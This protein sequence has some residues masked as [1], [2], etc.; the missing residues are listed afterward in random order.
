M[1]TELFTLFMGRL[2][3]LIVLC[4]PLEVFWMALDV[5]ILHICL[6]FFCLTLGGGT[7]TIR[8]ICDFFFH[9]ACIKFCEWAGNWKILSFYPNIFYLREPFASKESISIII[10]FFYVDLKFLYVKVAPLKIILMC[11]FKGNFVFIILKV[12]LFLL[13]IIQTI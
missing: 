12:T 10:W 5:L 9:F 11:I 4:F 13:K 3:I 7:S 2:L 8:K 1:F 6:C